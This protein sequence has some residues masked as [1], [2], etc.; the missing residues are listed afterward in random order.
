MLICWSFFVLDLSMLV[1]NSPSIFLYMCLYMFVYMCLC[2][3]VPLSLS[4][5]P[6]LSGRFSVDF[7]SPLWFSIKPS[8]SFYLE[9]IP[10]VILDTLQ[11]WSL[12]DNQVFRSYLWIRTGLTG[13][14][15]WSGSYNNSERK[16]WSVQAFHPFSPQVCFESVNLDPVILSFPYLFRS[17]VA[18]YS[19]L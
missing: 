8:Y 11:I 1:V 2:M 10:V 12:I 3:C 15:K 4:A 17:S 6:F 7:F 18:P 14:T 13:S 9:S 16:Q 19:L 5:P